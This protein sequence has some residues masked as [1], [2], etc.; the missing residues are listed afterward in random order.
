M[1]TRA[2]DVGERYDTK[3]IFS[4]VTP[5][6]IGSETDEYKG[7]TSDALPNVR[8]VFE[9]TKADSISALIH[10]LVE[11]QKDIFRKEKAKVLQ[12]TRTQEISIDPLQ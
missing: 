2:G 11:I 3:L 4:E 10:S 5:H 9:F 7:Q 12:Y 1:F 6:E 8:V